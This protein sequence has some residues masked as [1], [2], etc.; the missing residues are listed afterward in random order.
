MLKKISRTTMVAAILLAPL[1]AFADP[2]LV[3]F[4]VTSASGN[5]SGS[6]IVDNSVGNF[7][8]DYHSAGRDVLSGFSFS[9]L[10]SSWGP[11]STNM[12][13]ASFDA[14]GNITGWGVGSPLSC[15]A[16]C[17][18]DPGPTDFW[19]DS[20]SGTAAH[21]TDGVGGFLFG[22]V[23]WTST[24]NVPEPATLGLFGLSLLGLALRRRRA[25]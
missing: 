6:F 7:A 18:Q 8:D 19:V 25:S 16:G 17:V 24:R 1:S 5:G 9:W 21:H 20:F 10:G 11:G 15:G 13:G 4:N 12:Y 22:T 14:F 3:N 23:T 2:I